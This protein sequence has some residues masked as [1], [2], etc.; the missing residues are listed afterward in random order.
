MP[1]RV[2]LVA[3]VLVLFPAVSRGQVM[4]GSF[5]A[6]TW[7]P[8]RQSTRSVASDANGNFV[9]VWESDGQDGSGYGVFAKRFDA[10]GNPLTAEFRVNSYTTDAQ[11]TPAIAAD[12]DGNFVVAWTSVAQDGDS[13]GVFAQRYDAAG[14]PVGTEVRV[15]S[16][17]TGPQ[18]SPSVGG[19]AHVDFVFGQRWVLDR[20]FW[21]D[22]GDPA[23]LYGW[24]ATVTDGGD[25]DWSPDAG[26]HGTSGGLRGIVDD[27]NPI[28]VED[29][30][31]TGEHRYRA[32]FYFDPN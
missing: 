27:T 4:V 31:P 6:N 2:A 13:L 26:L 10:A 29:D 1:K 24:S 14:A 3:A 5:Q 11:L 22:F 9:V 7:T 32:R 19:S 20:I 28:Y 18:L 23:T 16:Y 15:N 8:G 25:L 17:T 21:D 30:T 12:A